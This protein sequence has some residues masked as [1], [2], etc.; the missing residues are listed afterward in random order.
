[1][2]FNSEV[3]IEIAFPEIL[4]HLLFHSKNI[5][6]DFKFFL[7]MVGKYFCDY[8]KTITLLQ[9]LRLSCFC[10]LKLEV[11]QSEKFSSSVQTKIFCG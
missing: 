11:H 8:L 10:Y 4:I 7:P 5:N 9:S 3:I 6:Y 2:I 1:M